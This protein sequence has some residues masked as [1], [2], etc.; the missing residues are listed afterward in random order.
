MPTLPPTTRTDPKIPE[1]K[2]PSATIGLF[3]FFIITT[4]YLLV[5]VNMNSFGGT[6]NKIYMGVYALLMILGEY[7]INLSL[8]ETMCGQRQWQSAMNVTFIPW[9]LIFGVLNAFLFLF[10]SWLK[11]FSNTFG[12]GIVK[13]MGLGEVFNKILKPKD[14][15]GITGDLQNV[16]ES[17][18]TDQSVLINEITLEEI[19][20]EDTQ[21]L[22]NADKIKDGVDLFWERMRGGNLLNRFPTTEM[23]TKTKDDLKYFMNVKRSIAEYVWYLLTGSLVTSVSYNYIVNMTCSSSLTD[24]QRKQAQYKNFMDKKDAAT[25]RDNSTVYT[26]QPAENNGGPAEDDGEDD[27]GDFGGVGGIFDD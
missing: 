14:Q 6:E 13:L 10:P 24:M 26:S 7:F 3:W 21:G 5:K 9:I 27:E 18:Y 1:R 15:A 23:E 25:Q 4:V 20:K 19:S 22:P 2:A 16:L 8:T 12:Y 17:I 11:P